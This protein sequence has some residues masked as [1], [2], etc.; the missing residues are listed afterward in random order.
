VPKDAAHRGG[1][2]IAERLAITIGGVHR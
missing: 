2:F 1:I